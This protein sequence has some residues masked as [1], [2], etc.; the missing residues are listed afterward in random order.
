M[1]EQ[2]DMELI[3]PQKTFQK[4]LY[5]CNNSHRKLVEDLLY[6][7]SFKKGLHKTG[8]DRKTKAPAWDQHP[9]KGICEGG[10]VHRSKLSPWGA[11]LPV[12][13]T[14]G[15]DRRAGGTWTL[16]W[17][18]AHV[19]AHQQPGQRQAVL[20]AATSLHLPAGMVHQ[21]GPQVWAAARC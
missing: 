11:S 9:R 1:A 13:R 16:L 8:K 4:Y 14:T 12:V 7:Q 20:M 5:M 19:L 10:K 15:T 17:R 6:N 21:V 18:S 2:E 3:S